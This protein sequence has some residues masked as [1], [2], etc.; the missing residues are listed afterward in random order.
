MNS[1]TT[2][3][4]GRAF[5]I[6]LGRLGNCVLSC[7]YSAIEGVDDVSSVAMWCGLTVGLNTM[8]LGT[9]GLFEW[10]TGEGDNDGLFVLGSL[11]GVTWIYVDQGVTVFFL[12]GDFLGTKSLIEKGWV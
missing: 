9:R 11:I 1:S 8:G 2:S 10:A 6:A 7:G 5:F 3:I 4:A 12:I